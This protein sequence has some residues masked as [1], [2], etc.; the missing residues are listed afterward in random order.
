VRLLELT[1]RFRAIHSA[2]ACFQKSSKCNF[3]PSVLKPRTASSSTLLAMQLLT[4]TQTVI[5][6]PACLR[7]EAWMFICQRMSTTSDAA[8]CVYISL[9]F[10]VFILYVT[11]HLDILDWL[12]LHSFSRAISLQ[13][14]PHY[15]LQSVL[16]SQ[17]FSS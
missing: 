1:A 13:R 10:A 14:N 7:T 5:A 6:G 15:H 12:S 9:V 8:V 4:H 17:V 11:R 16:C 3:C 2:R